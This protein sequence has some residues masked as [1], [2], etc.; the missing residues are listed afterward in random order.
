METLTIIKNV[1]LKIKC[2]DGEK[3]VKLCK[4][5]LTNALIWVKISM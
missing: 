1:C 3:I 2:T 5:G 4:K